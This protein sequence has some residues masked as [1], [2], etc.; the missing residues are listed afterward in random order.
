MTDDASNRVD[1]TP[2]EAVALAV[3][4]MRSRRYEVAGNILDQVLAAFPDHP[5][6]LHFAGLLAAQTGDDEVAVARVRRSLE[7]AP[8]NPHAWNNYGNLLYRTGERQ[9]AVDAWRHCLELA[10][11]FPSALSNIG[12]LLRE[13][14]DVDE[15][16]QLYRRALE[17]QPDFV[18]ALNNLG[19]IEMARN[20]AASAE[21]RFRRAIELEPG[22]G[23]AYTNLGDAL[24]RQGRRLEAAQ[25]FWKAIAVD[26]GDR[27]AR[28][29]LIYALVETGQRDKAIEVAR[30][31]V[32]AHPDDPRA[33]HH[34]AAVTGEAV[35]E[36]AGDAYVEEVFDRFASTFDASLG[37]LGYRAPQAIAD[38]L[39]RIVPVAA[40]DLDILDAG[41]G[42]GLVGP[43]VR[44]RA[45]RLV[46]VDLSGGMLVR[47]EKRGVY[48]D[49]IKAELTA[50]ISSET[51]AWDV[52]VSADTLCY[53]GPL[54]AVVATAAKALRPG[55]HLLF[56][57]EALDDD[58]RP[59]RLHPGN[60]RYAHSA[61]HVEAVAAAAGLDIVV[62]ERT[63]LRMEGGKP[64]AGHLYALRRS[65]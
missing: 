30:E 17:V 34:L 12:L 11:D 14:G 55:G 48:D 29:L 3:Q 13:E 25:W 5:D 54:D 31:W 61:A 59:H 36:R 27:L 9:A 16:E 39:A 19:T 43:L 49:L 7:V 38:L 18:E 42:T 46:G 2:E 10:P 8:G 24:E 23:D 32:A 41:C 44:T 65:A 33:H 6:G 53:F 4:A 20:E 47:A 26:K 64:V 40:A 22:F 35:P 21:A 15:A 63:E 45:R 50:M 58:P 57:L 51:E 60:G 56:S 52:V 37:R 28:K 1:S 62:H